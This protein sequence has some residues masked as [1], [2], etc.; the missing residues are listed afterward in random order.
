MLL[1][2]LDEAQ[3]DRVGCFRYEPVDGARRQRSRR[4][5]ARR[6]QGR[7]LA[8][9]HAAPAG[10][11]RAP[12]QAQG[13]HAAAGHHRRGR[14][15]PSPRAA[16]RATRRRSTAPSMWRAAGRCASARSPPSRSS[17]P[18][19]TIC[20]GRRSGS[21]LYARWL[22]DLHDRPRQCRQF[23]LADREGGREIDDRA[24]RADEDALAPRSA[25]AGHRDRRSGRARPRRL[26][27]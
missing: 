6:G 27:P 22:Q 15:R 20:T 2:W 24:E 21:D 17:A 8:S 9:L 13:R 12:P 19:P 10:D 14:R 23:L 25:R 7:A 18:T 26:R 16:A 11:L 3:L 1:D 5:G 4:A